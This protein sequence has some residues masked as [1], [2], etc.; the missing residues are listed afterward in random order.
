MEDKI[1]EALRMLAQAI[2]ANT[3]AT[4]VLAAKVEDNNEMEKIYS[5]AFAETRVEIESAL[6][7]ILHPKN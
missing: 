4:C 2:A 1:E 6:N 3:A 7:Q 5:E